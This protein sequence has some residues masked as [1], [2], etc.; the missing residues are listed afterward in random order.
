MTFKRKRPRVSEPIK[1]KMK[2][3]PNLM[4]LPKPIQ[5]QVRQRRTC[6]MRSGRIRMSSA[7]T[8]LLLGGE[9][10]PVYFCERMFC[11]EKPAGSICKELN[12]QIEGSWVHP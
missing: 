5:Y 9:T 12:K 4:G 3:I 8:R 6:A 2:F 7:E 1:V 11:P 10:A